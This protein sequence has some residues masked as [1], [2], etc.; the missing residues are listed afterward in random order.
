MIK[1]TLSTHD[2]IVALREYESAFPLTAGKIEWQ[3]QNNNVFW[4]RYSIKNKNTYTLQRSKWIQCKIV[5]EHDVHFF[6]SMSCRKHQIC[7]P[8]NLHTNPEK[9]KLHKM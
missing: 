1:S 2:I 7:N 5:L 9:K 8:W 6:L 4:A 3:Y